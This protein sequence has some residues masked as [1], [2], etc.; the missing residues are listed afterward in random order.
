M[1]E[2]DLLEMLLCFVKNFLTEPFS[3]K[4]YFRMG[5]T[6]VLKI[7]FIK[8]KTS[9]SKCFTFPCQESAKIV[10]NVDGFS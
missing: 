7:F 4:S 9:T 3:Y 10:P 2:N 8:L 1:K 6:T 5:Y